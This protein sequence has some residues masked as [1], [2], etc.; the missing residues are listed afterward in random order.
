[1][2]DLISIPSGCDRCGKPTDVL[3]VQ[4]KHGKRVKVGG[5]GDVFITGPNGTCKLPLVVNGGM[6]FT[7]FH[8][9]CA[10]HYTGQVDKEKA[11]RDANPEEY[12]KTTRR[13]G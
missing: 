8:S 10:E 1:M 11:W 2:Q 9:Y 7:R 13:F 6:F 4:Y 12:L 5:A 3:L